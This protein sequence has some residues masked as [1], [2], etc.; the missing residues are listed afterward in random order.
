[1]ARLGALALAVLAAVA[2]GA[3]AEAP[4][5]V[6]SMN[7]CTD[8]LA[9]LLA[10]EGQLHSVSYIASDRRASA[11]ADE[12]ESYV[13]NHGLAEEIYLMQPDLVIAGQ[14]ST[15]ATTDM[16]KRLGLPVVVIP[17]AASLEDVRDRMIRMGEVLHRQEAAAHMVAAYDAQLAALRAEVKDRPSAVLYHANGY[18]SGDNTLAGQILLA[19]GF[20][21]A[22][23]EAGYGSGMKLPLEVLAMTDP[24]AVITA[25]PYPGASRSE[26][27]MDHPAVRAFRQGHVGATM[28]DH[29]WVCGTPFV[30]RAIGGLG[31]A[32]RQITGTAE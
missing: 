15:Q 31:T 13:T 4:A 9:M 8:Q 12:A 2:G 30:L 16:L 5:R 14:Y 21:N 28:T 23:V 32:R 18:T 26:A 24:D 7:L 10:G 29:D 6:V 27:M 25:R 22:A 17:A 19:A 1:M 3:R 11:M 20:Q